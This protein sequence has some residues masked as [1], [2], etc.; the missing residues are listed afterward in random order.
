M[1][2]KAGDGAALGQAGGK[3]A[4]A[5]AVGANDEELILTVSTGDE[6]D[7]SAI[8]GP[9]RFDRVARVLREPSLRLAVR[10]H[11]EEIELSVPTAREN[12]LR[13]VW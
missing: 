9:C 6:R 13:A 10:L 12:D 8:E 4:K 5:R 11:Q 1:K 7:V 2:L 3:F